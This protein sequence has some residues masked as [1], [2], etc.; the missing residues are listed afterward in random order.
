M[1]Q[2]SIYGAG[3]AGTLS[4]MIEPFWG[5]G[6]VGALLSGKVA[7]LAHTNPKKAEADFEQ[8]NRGFYKKLA[9]KEKMDAMPF[10]KQLLRLAILKARWDCFRNPELKKAVKEPVLWFR[11]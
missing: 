8:F 2:V 6:V 3:L 10:N 7:A 1:K 9:R 5:Y 4:G 11:G